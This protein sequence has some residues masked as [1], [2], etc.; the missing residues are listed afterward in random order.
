MR[1]YLEIVRNVLDNGSWKP[2][3]TGIRTKSVSG[4]M[5]QHNM[6]DGFPLLTT[7]FVPFRLVASE[8][9]FFI[10][11][12][13][14]KRW[15][16][17]RGNHIWDEWCDPRIV[18]YG[19]DPETK[20]RM[21]EEP[22]LGEIYGRQWRDFDGAGI[23][24]LAN[25]V[26]TLKTTPGDRR[27]LCVA[28][29]PK[30]LNAQALPPCH[31]AFQVLVSGENLDTLDLLWNQ[32]SVDV[33]L[34]LPFNIASYGLLLHLLAMEAGLKPGKLVGFLADVHIYENHSEGLELQLTR[35]PLELPT[36]TIENFTSI[37][38]WEYTQAKIS[39]YKHHGKISFEI[40]V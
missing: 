13:N 33:A 29:N 7:K 6:S 8:L 19:N 21:M 16:Q 12:L 27:M 1:Q 9:E 4:A 38:D 18:P 5:F 39:G 37:F 30:Q 15:L 11:G 28:W 36:L 23:D 10:K 2:N 35:K 40:A 25:I 20:R 14:D 26:R 3:R 17:E 34:G 31:Y 22:K 24:Q 32:R